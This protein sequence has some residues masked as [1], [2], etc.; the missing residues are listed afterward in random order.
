MK[1][2]VIDTRYASIAAKYQSTWAKRLHCPA[3]KIEGF[4]RSATAVAAAIR[5]LAEQE[6]VGGFPGWTQR[7]Q[8]PGF[9]RST[10]QA[11]PASQRLD[12]QLNK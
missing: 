1:R 2:P 8:G 9:V 6:P 5:G 12:E 10:L 7:D 11:R 4:N 3:V